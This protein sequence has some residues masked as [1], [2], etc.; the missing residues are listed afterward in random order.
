MVVTFLLRI[1][2]SLTGFTRF[3]RFTGSML[4]RA[5]KLELELL[6]ALKGLLVVGVE[7]LCPAWLLV[8]LVVGVEDTEVTTG[9][10][11]VEA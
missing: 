11:K 5:P 9:V 6:R 1:H 10:A 4:A 7:G 2:L 3:T 8:P